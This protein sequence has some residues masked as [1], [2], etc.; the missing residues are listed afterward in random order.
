[1]LEII[2]AAFFIVS[3]LLMMITS[4]MVLHAC[5]FLEVSMRSAAAL[6]LGL[7]G[8]WCIVRALSGA[9]VGAGD[10][11]LPACVVVYIVGALWRRHGSPARRGTDVKV[12]SAYERHPWAG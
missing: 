11:L 10:L 8:A 7:A 12:A 4:R 9:E 5:R 6:L 2:V 1:M 3:G